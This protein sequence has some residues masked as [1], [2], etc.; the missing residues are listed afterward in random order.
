M[1]SGNLIISSLSAGYREDDAIVLPFSTV[2]RPGTLVCMAG[3]NGAGKSTLLRTLAALQKPLGG[4]ISLSGRRI[5]TLPP[6]LAAREV[7]IVLTSRRDI[8]P[9]MTGAEL[10]STGRIP[11]TGFFG[12]LAEKDIRKVEHAMDLTGSRP[13]ATRRISSLSDGELQRLL[14]ARA[15]AQDT[16]LILL[17]EP[18]AFLDIPGKDAAFSLLSRICREEGRIV[19]AASHDLR[20]ALRY[21]GVIWVIRKGESPQ[22]GESAAM[23]PQLPQ[24]YLRECMP[25]SAESAPQIPCNDKHR[26]E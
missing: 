2:V 18:T 15:L 23:L 22:C 26:K 6:S 20:P 24:Q 4:S 1:N 13:F 19:I 3:N 21:A 10:V 17:D 16:P 5:D 25:A 14:I 9:S 8:A 12:K 7:S 11:Y